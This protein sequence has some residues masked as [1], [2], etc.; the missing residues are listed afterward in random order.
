MHQLRDERGSLYRGKNSPV[1][2]VAVSNEY[3]GHLAGLDA[4]RSL[5]GELKKE[6][7]DV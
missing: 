6:P 2:T 5:D 1:I 3:L 4:R 7:I